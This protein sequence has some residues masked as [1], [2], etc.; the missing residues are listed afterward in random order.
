VT[1]NRDRQRTSTSQ[2][3]KK[4]SGI[5]SRY[6]S[7]KVR[8]E[9]RGRFDHSGG[10]LRAAHRDTATL[11]CERSDGLHEIGLLPGRIRQSLGVASDERRSDP[12]PRVRWLV[13]S[14]WE[15]RRDDKGLTRDWPDLDMPQDAP[16]SV[17]QLPERRTWLE[18]EVVAVDSRFGHFLEMEIQRALSK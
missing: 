18:Q 8:R 15:E 5:A 12:R 10:I 14:Y 16:D 17:R 3:P 2:E 1:R 11:R 6:A 13:P 9:Q 4:A 7:L